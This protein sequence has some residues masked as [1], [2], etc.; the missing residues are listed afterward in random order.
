MNEI[1]NEKEILN[2]EPD[3]DNQ[4]KI[5]EEEHA[6]IVKARRWYM[7]IASILVFVVLIFIVSFSRIYHYREYEFLGK[8]RCEYVNLKVDG[9]LVPNLNITD[10]N[11]CKPMYNIDYQDNRIAVF[12]IDVLGD[13]THIFNKTNQLDENGKYCILNCDSDNDGWPD[14]NLDLNGDGVADINIIR[15]YKKGKLCELNCDINYDSLPDTNIDVDGD[16]KADINVTEKNSNIPKYNIDYKGNRKKV[17]NVNENGQ[18][19]NPI[20]NVKDNPN[21]TKNCDIDGDGWP[22]YNIDLNNNEILL[23]ELIKKGEDSLPFNKG[24]NVDWKCTLYP[25]EKHCKTNVTTN[26]NVYINIDVDGD[27]NPDVNI[28]QDNG[29]TIINP[30]N[31]EIDDLKLNI[32]IDNDGFPEYNIDLNN[33][34]EADLNLVDDDNVCIKNCDTNHDGRSDH[35]IEYQEGHLILS[36]NINVDVDYNGTC[37]VN[38]DLNYDLHPDNNIDVDGNNIADIDVDYNQDQLADF[39]LDSNKDGKPEENL[40]AYGLGVCNFN[41]AGNNLVDKSPFCVRN[42]DTDGDGWPDKNVDIDNDGICD[43]NCDNGTTNIDKDNNYYLDSEYNS[44]AILDI[45]S[46]GNYDFYIMNPLEIKSS[47]IEPGWNDRYVIEVKNNSS[48]A[49]A[50]RVVWENVTNEFSD[51]NNMDYSLARSNTAFIEG[52]KAPRQTVILKDNVLLR[53]KSEAKFV[54]DIYFRETGLNQN[55]DSGKMFKGQ[56]KIELVK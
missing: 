39:N 53:A 22:D 37:D 55:V 30:I 11:K 13:R 34:G 56:L 41:C 14:Y 44:D 45:T 15:N 33:D 5:L 50:Y 8:N 23:N 28:S 2:Q 51:E 19:T 35:L 3:F 12:N 52:Y 32:D 42:C 40:D 6:L 17:F 18:I 49:I 31:K 43:F 16:G 47:D 4:A 29:E 25:S 24:K 38:C 48:Y 46:A 7:L 9:S 27:G 21:C 54:L 10:G 1:D 20:T 36:K 26:N